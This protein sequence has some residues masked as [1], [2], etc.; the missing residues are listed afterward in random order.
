MCGCGKK[1]SRPGSTGARVAAPAGGNINAAPAQR[2]G[3]NSNV[4]RSAPT[5]TFR[6]VTRGRV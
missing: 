2:S 4:I 5:P 3:A 1:F 6:T